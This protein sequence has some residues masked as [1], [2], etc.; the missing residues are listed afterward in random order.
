MEMMVAIGSIVVMVTFLLIVHRLEATT[1]KPL[2]ALDRTPRTAAVV[3]VHAASQSEL[4]MVEVEF[5]DGAGTVGRACLVDL[6]DSSAA[7][8]FTVGSRWQVYSFMKDQSRCLLAE[9]HDDVPR[10]GYQ[11]DGL[12][13]G[14]ERLTFPPR[15]GSPILGVMR[16]AGEGDRV[17][18]PRT[19]WPGDPASAWAQALSAARPLRRPRP[20]PPVRSTRDV[21]RDDASLH[22]VVTWGAPIFWVLLALAFTGMLVWFRLDGGEVDPPLW[23]AVGL[24]LAITLG[25]LVFRATF[26]PRWRGE[27]LEHELSEGVLCDVVDSPMTIPGGDVDSTTAIAVVV[28]LPSDQAERIVEALRRWAAQDEARAA[29]GQEPGWTV[30]R[31]LTS[32]ELFGE[33]A[34]G[35]FLVRDCP[36]EP[37]AWLLVSPAQG[38]DYPDAPYRDADVTRITLPKQRRGVPR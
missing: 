16:F 6:F 21:G 25:I 29:W 11:L 30:Y 5:P 20:L 19:S 27:G 26:Y 22:R 3:A 17:V 24:A 28:D 18:G 36:A 9:E 14:N 12:R 37:G 8:A 4:Q 32:A 33:D 13:I 10:S 23:A 38:G 15:Q 7:R 34:A 31:A 2:P 35:G 1:R